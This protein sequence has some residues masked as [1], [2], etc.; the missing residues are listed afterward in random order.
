VRV[1]TVPLLLSAACNGSST[2]APSSAT[3]AALQAVSISTPSIAGGLEVTGTVTLTAAAPSGGALIAL[4][5]SLAAAAVPP[6]IQIDAGSTS[7]TF[8]I[9]TLAAAGSTT[10]TITATYASISKTATLNIGRLTLQGLSLSA[11]SIASGQSVTGTLA[12]AAPAAAGG[13]VVAL[14]SS[15]PNVVVPASVTL[16]AG[17][18]TATFDVTTT[19]AGGATVA[20][21]SATIADSGSVRTA[22]LTVAP[23]QLD[24]LSL[25]FDRWPGGTTLTALVS[26]N[27]TAP[28]S[29]VTVALTSSDPVASVPA[30]VTIPAGA[31]IAPFDITLANT[32]PARAV[33]ITASYG[34]RSIA[35]SLT[36]I[37]LPKIGALSCTPL[38]VAGGGTIQCDGSIAVPAPPGGWRLAMTSSDPSA[39]GPAAIVVNAGSTAFSFSISTSAVTADTAVTIHIVDAATGWIVYSYPLTVTMS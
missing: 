2:T 16:A 17:T 26:L 3:T 27:V 13:V 19:A 8:P 38:S 9:D 15:S 7:Q 10:A 34:G 36:V 30:S 31:A 5:S 11:A 22:T 37:A 33:T 32:P 28:A 23:L 21:I 39:S 14:A 20:T 25:G 35:A 4:S 18:S 12:L 29:G 6:S 24:S 1:C